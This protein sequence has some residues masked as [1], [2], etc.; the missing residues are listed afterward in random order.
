MTNKKR[1][2]SKGPL[3]PKKTPVLQGV[4][5]CITS[6]TK[7]IPC[8]KFPHHTPGATRPKTTLPNVEFMLKSYGITVRYNVI[9]KR[10][11]YWIPG[12]DVRQD[13][14]DNVCLTHILSL[15]ALNGL[16]VTLVP[17]FIEAIA[18]ANPHNPVSEWIDS[19]PWDG[20]DR[21]PEFCDTLITREEYP[22]TFRDLLIR[23]WL[24]SAAAALSVSNFRTRGVL[25]LQGGQNV[26]KTAWVRALVSDQVLGD[27][28][29]KVDHHMDGNNK[30]S[31]LGAI[32]HWIVEIGELDSSFK[33]DVARL[34]GFLTA[35]ADKVRRPYAKAESEYQRRT[36]FCAT[37]NE[38]NF[39]V[40]HTGNSRFWT[41]ALVDVR[42]E[43]NI[44]MQ[45]LWA[46]MS[47]EIAQGAKWWLA[48]DEE[49]MLAT[50]N[51]G[52][53]SVSATREMILASV[54]TKDDPK[55]D[56]PKKLSASQVLI[57]HCLIS[58]PSNAQCKD[59]AHTLRD[60]YGEPTKSGG[61]SKWTVYGLKSSFE[62]DDTTV[63]FEV[64]G[65][66]AHAVTDDEDF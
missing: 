46:Q 8:N 31:Q 47:Q 37:V 3:G 34:K 33:K 48:R 61:V 59:A 16:Q 54:V 17:D 26:G 12:L 53:L 64:V 18:D 55:A 6:S 36:V 11:D 57:Q 10:V 14:R 22:K 35:S 39:L 58:N 60:L 32:T 30:D 66:S 15:A 40:D 24:L 49:V 7:P 5:S 45:Q 13:N 65:S 50:I 38:G 41:I 28:V 52:H 62:L 56:K 29:V 19:I 23:K 20:F 9:K 25:T 63:E 27:S 51:A 2:P 43:H 4:K 44:D 21:I 1:I 42:Y